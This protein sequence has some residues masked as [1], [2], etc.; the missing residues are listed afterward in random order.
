M[1]LDGYHNIDNIDI[2]QV[3][4]NQMAENNQDKEGMT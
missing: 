3:V 2:S 1:Y 4:I